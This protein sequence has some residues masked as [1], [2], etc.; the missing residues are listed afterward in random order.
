MRP[1]TIDEYIA[2]KP[3]AVRPRLHELREAI[4]G[5]LPAHTEAVKWGE[6]AFLHPDGMILVVFAAYK[7]HCNVVVTPSAREAL[8]D[9]LSDYETG[10]GSLKIPHDQ[11]LPLD[12]I[13]ALVDERLREYNQDG[14]KWM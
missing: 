13:R 6:A 5:R 12:L 2:S 4:A 10:K 9:R 14:T 8:A 11:E 1:Q 7:G 3:E